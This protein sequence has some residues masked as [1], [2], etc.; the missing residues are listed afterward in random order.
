M[1]SIYKSWSIKNR[2]NAKTHHGGPLM[3]IFVSLF[4]ESIG[5]NVFNILV[6]IFWF[7]LSV[8]HTV[9]HLY[10]TLFSFNNNTSFYRMLFYTSAMVLHLPHHVYSRISSHVVEFDI[11]ETNIL[12]ENR[13]KGRATDDKTGSMSSVMWRHRI[14]L[15]VSAYITFVLEAV[16]CRNNHIYG[17]MKSTEHYKN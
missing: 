7:S 3:S 15:F 13:D 12:N 17:R 11:N 9:C 2:F 6:I 8:R 10:V 14:Y 4:I 5:R 1:G 16:L